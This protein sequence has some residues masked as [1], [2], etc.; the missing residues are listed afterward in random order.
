VV[1]VLLYAEE[2]DQHVLTTLT[3]LGCV[4]FR[5]RASADDLYV[6]GVMEDWEVLK[7][8][9]Q[10]LENNQQRF[11][12]LSVEESN[13]LHRPFDESRMTHVV[14]DALTAR[15]VTLLQTAY[16]AGYFQVPKKATSK[17]LAAELDMSQSTFSEQLR[18]AQTE[19][20]RLVFGSI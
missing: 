6:G 2:P 13:T 15:H 7:T 14:R 12:L 9:G 3:E 20:Y 17:E 10:E 11:D 8:I 1:S 16:E 19:L 4:P 5:V 18:T